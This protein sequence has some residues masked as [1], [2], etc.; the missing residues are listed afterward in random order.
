MKRSFSLGLLVSTLAMVACLVSP[1]VVPAAEKAIVGTPPE[2]TKAVEFLGR[3]DQN[4]SNLTHYGYLTFIFGLAD[5]L[6]FLDSNTRTEATARFT[7]FATTTLSSRFELGNLIATT[8]P[9]TLTI[10]FTDTPGSDFNDPRSFASGQPIA[11][12]SIQ[13]HNILNVQAPNQGLSSAIADLVQLHADAFTLEGRRY[14]LGHKG[15]R[16]RVWATG[17][18]TRIQVDPLLSFFLLAGNITVTGR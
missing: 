11:T 17:Q 15:L 5:D 14:F 7:F 9:G 18:G 1:T 12:F 10:Y 13:Y 8:A 4:G 3:S 6:L 2:G 16:E